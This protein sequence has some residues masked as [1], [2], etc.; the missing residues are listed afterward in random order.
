MLI[1]GISGIV[2][3]LLGRKIFQGLGE[4]EV[5]V[6]V[7]A[8]YWIDK[9]SPGESPSITAAMKSQSFPAYT[10]NK[11]KQSCAKSHF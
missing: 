4:E 6:L 2:R 11:G 10:K 1:M 8:L 7:Q 5:W 9:K 3:E